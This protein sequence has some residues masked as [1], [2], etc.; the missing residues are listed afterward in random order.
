MR[1]KLLGFMVNNGNNQRV[2][3]LEDV[4]DFL[5]RGWNYVAKLYDEKAVIK[6][7]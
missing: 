4:E 2:V 3:R 7:P 6:L 5:S 1:R